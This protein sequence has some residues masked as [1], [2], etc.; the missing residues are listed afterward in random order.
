MIFLI[1]FLLSRF[2]GQDSSL[3][4]SVKLSQER[5]PT[6]PAPNGA[7]KREPRWHLPDLPHAHRTCQEDAA[8]D[9]FLHTFCVCREIHRPRATL[10]GRR[11]LMP[12]AT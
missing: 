6:G 5:T 7:V 9:P 10:R 11:T 12:K 2:N 3:V 8:N 4:K 1:L